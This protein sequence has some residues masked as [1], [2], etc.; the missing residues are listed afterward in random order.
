MRI[1]RRD[2]ANAYRRHRTDGKTGAA[3]GAGL[4][5]KLR[6]EGS[7]GTRTEADRLCRTDIATGL[8]IGAVL[9]KTALADHCD[10]GKVT[11][12]AD[13]DRLRTEFRALAAEGTLGD[14][15]IERRAILDQLDDLRRTGV[16]ASSAA[17]AGLKAGRGCSWRRDTPTPPLARTAEKIPP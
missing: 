10:V 12:P 11:W 9:G 5:A 7:A 8:A 4:F 3:A 14:G 6:Q 2:L 1:L 16:D 17:G 13:E 15:E